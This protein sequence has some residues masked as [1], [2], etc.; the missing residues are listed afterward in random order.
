V[1]EL[2]PLGPEIDESIADGISLCECPECGHEHHRIDATGTGWGKDD[3][4]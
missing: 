3:T 1:P 4:D 2:P